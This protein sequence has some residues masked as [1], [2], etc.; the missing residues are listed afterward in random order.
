VRVVFANGCFDILTVGHLHLLE[1]AKR[2]GTHLIVG[3]NSDSSVRRRKG[4]TRPI[5]T[6]IDRARLLEAIHVVDEVRVF[7]EDTPERLLHELRPDVYVLGE[8][9]RDRC[10]GAEFAG[11]V[12]FVERL[13]G[14]STTKIIEA[15]TLAES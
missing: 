10:P 2:L 3:I 13:P 7:D 14:L 11:R 15:A 1:T 5:N 6:E 4:P 9:Y 12:H 8:E